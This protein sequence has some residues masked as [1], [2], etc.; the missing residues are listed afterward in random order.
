M[1]LFPS[2]R[3]IWGIRQGFVSGVT[4]ANMGIGLLNLIVTGN[5][6]GAAMSAGTDTT[7]GARASHITGTSNVFARAGWWGSNVT[8]RKYNPTLTFR[9]RLGAAQTSSNA[10][11][12]LGF[13]NV[14][15][16]PT[17]G[18]SV[19]STMLNTKIGALFGFRAADTT[20]MFM[21]NNAQATAVYTAQTG[22]P[23]SGVTDATAHT[24]SITL[25]DTVPSINWSFDGVVQTPI[26]DTTNSVPPSTT[27]L[28]P[29]MILEAQSATDISIKERFTYLSHDAA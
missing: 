16:Q 11:L 26:T 18:T 10:M 17:A 22:L 29:I 19:L 14:T 15:A 28:N 9:F 5:G 13:I 23:A 1:V 27:V 21:S 24:L 7:D 8:A 12:Y 2:S 25:N 3:R 20:W 6:T 4:N